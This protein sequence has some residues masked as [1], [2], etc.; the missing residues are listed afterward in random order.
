MRILAAIFCMAL[1]FFVQRA[2]GQDDAKIDLEQLRAPTA[3]AATII[4][5]QPNEVVRPK[6]AKDLE[7]A[8]LTKYMG[9]GNSINIPDNF[10][11][12][13]MP[14][15][16]G[17]RKN[18]DIVNDYLNEK[19]GNLFWQNLAIS[20]ASTQ[21]FKIADSINSNAVGFGFRSLLRRG[22][23][24]PEYKKLFQVI[25]RNSD[26]Q[27]LNVTLATIMDALSDA[28]VKT[29]EEFYEKLVTHYKTT[30]S[31][32]GLTAEEKARYD[33]ALE[34]VAENISGDYDKA[35]F[36][37]VLKEAFDPIIKVNTE[38]LKKLYQQFKTERKGLQ[39]EVAGALALNFPTNDFEFSTAPKSGLWVTGTFNP[40]KEKKSEFWQGTSLVTMVRYLRNDIDYYQQYFPDSTGYF[41]H[42]LDLGGRLVYQA[43]K[44]SVEF[45]LLS[46]YRQSLLER[47]ENL[48]GSITKREKADWDWKYLMNINYAISK[49]LVIN[50]SFGKQ[51]EPAFRLN[52]NLI[53]VF[54]LNF[55]FGGPKVSD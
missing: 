44:F 45:E 37:T 40:S 18:I 25:D 13:G 11:L 24:F 49:N 2:Q 29:N 43:S 14:Y 50:Y 10:M 8:I 31:Y 36:E 9:E 34:E 19:P 16:M 6:S 38:A 7:A 17:N 21:N 51:L 42:N 33:A 52:G 20:I 48:D 12:E 1:L 46:R 5:I 22:D 30:T 28:G 55:A 39:I 23:F 26:L 35:V 3:P 15:W 41:Q 54:S 53:S 32:T 27:I 4:S 47:I